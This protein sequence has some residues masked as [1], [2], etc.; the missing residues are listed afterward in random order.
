MVTWITERRDIFK[1]Y[2]KLCERLAGELK[3]KGGG[4]KFWENVMEMTSGFFDRYSYPVV[5]SMILDLLDYLEVQEKKQAEEEKK[6]EQVPH[7]FEKIL[8]NR[9]S[10]AYKMIDLCRSDRIIAKVYSDV[11]FYQVIEEIEK[12]MEMLKRAET[13]FLD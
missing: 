3:E 4:E 12:Y 10:E 1:E 9:L 13:L 2:D 7:P 6:M 5:K 11:N 8:E